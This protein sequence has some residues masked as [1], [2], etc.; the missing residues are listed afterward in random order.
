MPV[1]CS[2]DYRPKK[3]EEKPEATAPREPLPEPSPP[4]WLFTST[5]PAG[6]YDTI[7]SRTRRMN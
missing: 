4:P 6:F 2:R 3:Q 7:F 1:Y 5:S